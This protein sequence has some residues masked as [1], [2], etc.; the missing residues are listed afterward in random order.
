MPR[1]RIIGSA[2]VMITVAAVAAVAVIRFIHDDSRRHYLDPAG[3][4]AHGEGAYTIDG[5]PIRH[6]P[7]QTPVPIASVAKVMT[8]LIVLRAAPLRP[9]RPGFDLTVSGC[10]RRGRDRTRR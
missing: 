7:D 3:W 4:P 9:G 10:R 8:A 1:I 5:G 2:A 6:S